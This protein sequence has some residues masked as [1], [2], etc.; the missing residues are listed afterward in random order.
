MGKE[1]WISNDNLSAQNFYQQSEG[2]TFLSNFNWVGCYPGLH[3]PF[4]SDLERVL[5]KCCKV[6]NFLGEVLAL[7]FT[8]MCLKHSSLGCAKLFG[9]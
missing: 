5:W 9:Q 4:C 7:K 3:L 6:G 1:G 2:A 8:N